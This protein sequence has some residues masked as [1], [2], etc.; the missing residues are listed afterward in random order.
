MKE[1]E[2]KELYALLNQARS[3]I[4]FPFFSLL[5]SSSENTS[6]RIPLLHKPC[7]QR[8]RIHH[9]ATEGLECFIDFIGDMH[10]F[11]EMT[12]QR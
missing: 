7:R 6:D 1:A 12:L 10:K 11:A 3:H 4:G 5:F 8:L 9:L 2:L